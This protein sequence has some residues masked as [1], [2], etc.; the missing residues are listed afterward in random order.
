MGKRRVASIQKELLT[1]SR[2]SALAGV[3]IFNNPQILFKSELFIVSM[4]IAWTY[5]LHAW[6][7]REQIDYRYHGIKNGRK[8]FDRT[9][10]GSYKYWELERCLNWSGSPIDKHTANNL[11]FL[12]GIRHEIEHQ[13]T[14]RIDDALSAKFQA[15][16]LNYNHYIKRLFG[17]QH[18]IDKYLSVSLQFSAIDYDQADSL[19]NVNHLPKQIGSYIKTLSSP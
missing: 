9:K 7:R 19:K 1:K 2:E 8:V 13:M 5:L 14:S 16:C 3:Q 6:C 4:N 12:I 11:R 10:A 18:A 17:D 15:C